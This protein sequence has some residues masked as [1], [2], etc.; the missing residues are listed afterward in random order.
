MFSVERR[1]KETRLYREAIRIKKDRA[2][3]FVS[4]YPSLL[5][6]RWL[7]G[8]MAVESWLIVLLFTVPRGVVFEEIFAYLSGFDLFGNVCTLVSDLFQ[9]QFD[10][11][12]LSVAC[13]LPK[14]SYVVALRSDVDWRQDL[15]TSLQDR[16]P[17]AASAWG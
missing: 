4:T 6:R 8:A 9:D 14:C 12:D 17:S 1:T 3:R 7:V 2:L 5:T 15:A 16:L 13:G 10:H 11:F